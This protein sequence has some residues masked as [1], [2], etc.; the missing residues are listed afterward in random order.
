[1]RRQRRAKYQAIKNGAIRSWLKWHWSHRIPDWT[2]RHQ[3]M[4][5]GLMLWRRRE[6]LA[7]MP[8]RDSDSGEPL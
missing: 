5:H 7:R 6:E 3:V 2:T 8:P 1:M 4:R